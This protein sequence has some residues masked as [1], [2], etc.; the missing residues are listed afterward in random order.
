MNYKSAVNLIKSKRWHSETA[1]AVLQY[2]LGFTN[3]YVNLYKWLGIKAHTVEILHIS[4][5]LGVESSVLEE[6]GDV[7]EHLRKKGVAYL[8]K[9]YNLW[10]KIAKKLIYLQEQAKSLSN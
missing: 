8:R 4:H 2:C 10:K 6:R 9:K 3:G 7:F 5:K 1:P